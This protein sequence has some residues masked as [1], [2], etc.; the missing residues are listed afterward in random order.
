MQVVC[1][2][3]LQV[4][5]CSFHFVASGSAASLLAFSLV[6]FQLV[7]ISCG[8]YASCFRFGCSLFFFPLASR[9]AVMR[10]YALF[11]PFGSLQVF[12]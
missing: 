12:V 4:V 6:A 10:F 11:T 8:W 7:I 3:I 2:W 1:V 5:S 9:L